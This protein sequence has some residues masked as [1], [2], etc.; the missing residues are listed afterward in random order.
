MSPRQEYARSPYAFACYNSRVSKLVR[1]VKVKCDVLLCSV[2]G[3]RL[4]TTCTS[5]TIF[6]FRMHKLAL[7]QI[8]QCLACE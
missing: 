6:G 5:V 4:W 2:R 3:P 7:E 8:S 1:T